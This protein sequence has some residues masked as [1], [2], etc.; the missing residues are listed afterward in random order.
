MSDSDKSEKPYTKTNFFMLLA[1]AELG[2]GAK[3][4]STAEH[5]QAVN[6]IM[7]GKEQPPVDEFEYAKMDGEAWKEDQKEL[8]SA[9][10]T[11]TYLKKGQTKNE[12]LNMVDDK[13]RETKSDGRFYLYYSGHGCK[14]SG[15][16]PTYVTEDWIN[17]QNYLK[18]DD[19]DSLKSNAAQNK[20]SLID[21]LLELNLD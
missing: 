8:Y 1:P 16:W 14:G 13:A 21:F 20:L 9:Q 15:N 2:H 7:P 5:G 12:I 11:P 19:V 18:K 4:G 3:D 6:K 17:Q 10:H